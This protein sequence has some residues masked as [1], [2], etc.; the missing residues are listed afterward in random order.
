ML[1]ILKN[2]D[3]MPAFAGEFFGNDFLSNFFET[4]TRSSIPSVNIIEGQNDYKIEVAAPGLQKEDF[5][6]DLENDVLTIVSEKKQ[7]TEEKDEKYM[8]REFCYCSF[9][10]SFILPD[11][12]EEDKINA[13]HKDGILTVSIPKKEKA[14]EKPS[15][16]IAIS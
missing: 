2:R 4:P 3:F 10:R 1:P 16:F 6:I 7:K 11:T 8:R 14:K 13:S 5:K 15:R 12:I 9:R